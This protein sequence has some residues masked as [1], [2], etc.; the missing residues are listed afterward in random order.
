MAL[1]YGAEHLPRDIGRASL[2]AQL[3]CLQNAI[4][5][6]SE[7]SCTPSQEEEPKYPSNTY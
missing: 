2:E 6:T 4:C 7:E 1:Q 5:T 3:L